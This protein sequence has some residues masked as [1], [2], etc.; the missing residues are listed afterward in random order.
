MK[1][2]III[3]LLIIS[4]FSAKQIQAQS[5]GGFT[6]GETFP[7]DTEATYYEKNHFYR[8]ENRMIAGITGYTSITVLPSDRTIYA[9]TFRGNEEISKDKFIKF[10]NK[11]EKKYNVK[12]IEY[13]R[14]G[15][16]DESN[17]DYSY[18]YNSEKL[19]VYCAKLIEKKEIY[20]RIE[21][22]EI[23]DRF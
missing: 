12:L 20:L 19:R 5:L 1:K 8:F 9:V 22:E 21:S 14:G 17:V 3:A 16:K 18:E 11:V 4:A 23:R 15:S 6:L 7:K 10:K 13:G 2:T